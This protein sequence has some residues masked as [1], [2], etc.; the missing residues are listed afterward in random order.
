MSVVV[1]V[2]LFL[3]LHLEH[4]PHSTSLSI[5]SWHTSLLF[6]SFALNSENLDPEEDFNLLVDA[7]QII[8][9]DYR[10]ETKSE[11][12]CSGSGSSSSRR[13]CTTKYTCD[14]IYV[15]RFTYRGSGSVRSVV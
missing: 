5:F 8:S 6:L 11:E 4:A 3:A 15:Y 7:C 2:T 10:A 1:H 12:S 9:V 13:R 14:D